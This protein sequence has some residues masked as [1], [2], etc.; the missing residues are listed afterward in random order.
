LRHYAKWDESDQ[1]RRMSYD[2]PYM[3]N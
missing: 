2:L 1:K 3:C